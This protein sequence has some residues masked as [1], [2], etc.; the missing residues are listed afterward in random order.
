MLISQIAEDQLTPAAKEKITAAMKTFNEKEGDY[1]FVTASCWMD[2]IRARTRDYNEWHYVEL[3]FT[4]EGTPIPDGSERPNVV[5]GIQQCVEKLKSDAPA[6][7]KAEALVMLL[8]LEGDVHQPLHTT[9]NKDAGGNRREVSNMLSPEVDLL[10]SKGNN[11]H[12]FWD[13][14]YRRN[15]A[16]GMSDVAYATPLH[17][18]AQPLA[19]HKEAL[20]LVRKEASAVAAEFPKSVVTEQGDAEGWALESHRIGMDFAYGKLPTRHK[21]RTYKLTESYVE[22]ARA[23]ARQQVAKAGY[24]LGALLNEIYGD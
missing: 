19:G 24:R 7:D 9:A 18:P 20:P 21:D 2:D 6:A 1:D 13:S 4:P 16:D 3:P 14:A 23:I 15:F 22:G 8:H 10:F 12:Y 11:L 17:D 5:W